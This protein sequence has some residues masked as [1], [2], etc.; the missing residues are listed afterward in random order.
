MPPRRRKT[1]TSAFIARSRGSK[2][3]LQS[4]NC[5]RQAHGLLDDA[6]NKVMT[7]T[8][9]TITIAVNRNLFRKEVAQQ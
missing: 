1:Q 4:R 5:G 3:S 9:I 8:D 6:S 2:V 7:P